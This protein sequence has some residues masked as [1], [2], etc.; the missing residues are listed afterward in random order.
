MKYNLLPKAQ[1]SAIKA[2]LENQY[3]QFQA[4][5]LKLDMSRGKPGADQLDLAMGLLD[6]ISS[7]DSVLA[8]DGMDCRNYGGLDGIPEAKKLMGDIM[9]AEPAEVIVGGNSSLNLMY[10][11]MIRAYYSGVAGGQPWSM[12]Q[13]PKFLCPVPGYDRHF[14]ISEFLGLQMINVPTDENGPDMDMVEYLAADPSVKGI[15][16]VP[17]YANPSGIVY[18]DEVIE[19]LAG[20]RAA[21]KDFRIFYDNSYA[22]HHLYEDIPVRKSLLTAAKKHGRENQVYMFSSTSKISFAGGGISA[23]AA[24]ADN[25]A[26]IKKQMAIQTIGHDKINQLRHVRFYKD[27]EGIKAHMKKHA[28]ILRP[29]FEMVASIFEKNLAGKGVG[30]WNNPRGGYFISFNGMPGTATRIIALCKAAGVVLTGAGAAF[31]YGKDPNDE[32][33][34]IAPSYPPVAEL[35]TAAELFTVCVQLAAV[36]KLLGE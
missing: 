13:K 11:M 35:E 4:R 3:Q 7:K 12:T 8:S 32:N 1:L 18:S 30:S 31:P 20:L 16:C 2:D 29:K 15:W 9:G 5:N 27:A 10:D 22:V 21:S 23:F 19:R 25:I 28:E 36:E 26:Y 33:I 6:A 34:R 17:M 14:A 24:S